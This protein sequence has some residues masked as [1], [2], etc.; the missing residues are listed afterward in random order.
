MPMSS[1][2]YAILCLTPRPLLGHPDELRPTGVAMGEGLH[3][4]DVFA[5]P[6]HLP[7]QDGEAHRGS[8]QAH[9]PRGRLRAC[10]GLIARATV[11]KHTGWAGK[12]S[13]RLGRQGIT[14]AESARNH[15]GWADKESH[16]LGRQGS[17]M[18]SSL[19]TGVWLYA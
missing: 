14:Q 4:P 7:C 18:L 17:S 6:H 9:C 1:S 10:A 13:H 15:T 19:H 16:R 2:L 5:L 3:R 8:H 12:V 11:W